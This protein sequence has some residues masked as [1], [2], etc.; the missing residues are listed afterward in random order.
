MES[1]D[2][3][4]NF[5]IN[6]SS[7]EGRHSMTRGRFKFRAASYDWRLKWKTL[8][9]TQARTG[10]EARL[11]DEMPNAS[12]KHRK[13]LS[14]QMAYYPGKTGRGPFT[15]VEP[16]LSVPS[17]ARPDF[18]SPSRSIGASEA[19]GATSPCYLFKDLPRDSTSKTSSSSSGSLRVSGFAGTST[20]RDPH[21]AHGQHRHPPP[22]GFSKLS[23]GSADG[24]SRYEMSSSENSTEM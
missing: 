17:P 22:F 20:P 9:V 13:W 18:S 21:L 7:G 1:T 23:F 19:S 10:I 11:Q 2:G 3:S 6:R 4:D 16:R 24:F 15:P 5:V 12:L 8:A 14:L